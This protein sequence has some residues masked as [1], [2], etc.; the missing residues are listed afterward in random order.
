MRVSFL[1]LLSRLRGRLLC[2]L[3]GR[4]GILLGSGEFRRKD[5]ELSRP[6]GVFDRD[7]SVDTRVT[8]RKGGE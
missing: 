2:S 5:T 7:W 6:G 3:I 8:R 1:G 4:G